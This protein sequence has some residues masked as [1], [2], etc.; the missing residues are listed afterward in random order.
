MTNKKT[1]EE[2]LE[3]KDFILA[4]IRKQPLYR[5]DLDEMFGLS[6]GQLT[7]ALTALKTNDLIATFKDDMSKPH[8]MRRWFKTDRTETYL[9]CRQASKSKSTKAF[10]MNAHKG[11]GFLENASMKVTSD[12]HHPTGN[13]T[14]V[15]AWSGYSSMAMM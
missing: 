6:Y 7:N 8:N 13:K 12:D 15:S 2:M 4:E 14:R 3:I 5:H 10:L 1:R 9:E 11:D